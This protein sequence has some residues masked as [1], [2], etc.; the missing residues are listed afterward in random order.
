MLNKKP[1]NYNSTLFLILLLSLIVPFI[2]SSCTDDN[3]T[4]SPQNQNPTYTII[5]PTNNSII[6]KGIAVPI[7]FDCFNDQ[8][9][10]FPEVE[11]F[12]NDINIQTVIDT[13]YI[14]YWNTRAF[15]LGEYQVIVSSTMET[16]TFYDTV[17]VTLSNNYPTAIFE[18]S[19]SDSGDISTNF[20]YDASL[21]YDGGDPN[22]ELEVRWDFDGDKIW[23]TEWSR[24]KTIVKRFNEVGVYNTK[25]EVR[26]TENLAAS[27]TNLIHILNTP[28][29]GNAIYINRPAAN[30]NFIF[31]FT[32]D[33]FIDLESNSI[34][35]E[36]QWDFDGNGKW[37]SEWSLEHES[38]YQFEKSGIFEFTYQVKDPHGMIGPGVS[39]TVY[40]STSDI[41]QDEMILIPAGSFT[42]GYNGHSSSIPLHNVTLTNDFEIA[43][44]TITNELYCDMLN[45]ALEEGI[46]IADNGY[47]YTNEGF[48]GG[49]KKL[50]RT[51][52]SCEIE[53]DTAGFFYV[54]DEKNIFPVRRVTWFGAI[55]YCNM[56][57]RQENL[58]ELYDFSTENWDCDIYTPQ[59]IGYRLPTEAEWEWSARYDDE[60]DYPWGNFEGTSLHF[61]NSNDSH[62]SLAVGSF[63]LKGNSKTGLC[64]LLGNVKE[65]CNDNYGEYPYEDQINPEGPVYNGDKVVRSTIENGIYHNGIR[66]SKAIDSHS[67]PNGFRIVKQ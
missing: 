28:P 42:M 65:W 35:L 58:T 26:D 51:S 12:I 63:A 50:I 5:S 19:L 41:D 53:W 39:D 33:E 31:E 45:Y 32:A 20:T 25:L 17:N 44:Y 57:S 8:S 37:D 36:V 22:S 18:V 13:P 43:K 55:F 1:F 11:F 15:D 59:N 47:V 49:I 10:V 2:I 56:L 46:I 34:D 7:Q 4:T 64:D 60:R 3:S 38:E 67:A 9:I 52:S 48:S 62:P 21:S 61:N 30:E 40:V 24:E 66:D 16:N 6:E 29:S 54:E 14:S 23:D 27:T